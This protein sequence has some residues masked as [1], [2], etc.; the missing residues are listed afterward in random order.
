MMLYVIFQWLREKANGAG[1]GNDARE[2]ATATTS[3][4]ADH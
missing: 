4:A 1:G 3:G 2:P